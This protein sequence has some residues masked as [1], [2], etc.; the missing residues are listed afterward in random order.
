MLA[1]C[2]AIEIDV[3]DGTTCVWNTVTLF[4]GSAERVPSFG[5]AIAERRENRR[6]TG[7]YLGSGYVSRRLRTV[8][9]RLLD[10]QHTDFVTFAKACEVEIRIMGDP[11]ICWPLVQIV[12]GDTHDE[13]LSTRVEQLERHINWLLASDSETGRALL[14]LG[15]QPLKDV[16]HGSYDLPGHHVLPPGV[17]PQICIRDVRSVMIHQPVTFLFSLNLTVEHANTR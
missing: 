1:T 16:V 3:P 7:F 13:Q 2:W 5:L 6:K 11:V 9:V 4:D 17:A 15:A 12:R 8:D 14:K 10:G